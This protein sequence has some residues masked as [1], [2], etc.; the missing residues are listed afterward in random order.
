MRRFRWSDL[1]LAP[2][3]RRAYVKGASAALVL[4]TLTGCG[5]TP[6]AAP[7][8]PPGL[9]SLTIS[10]ATLSASAIDDTLPFTATVRD[11]AGSTRSDV[12]VTWSSSAP[13]IARSLGGGRFLAAGEG[14]AVI[15]AGTGRLLDSATVTVQQAATVVTIS[16]PDTNLQLGGTLQLA[17]SA[18]DARGH[19]MAPTFSWAV[20]DPTV[21]GID[22]IGLLT[23]RALGAFVARASVGSRSASLQLRTVTRYVQVEA[24]YYEW[25]AC[26]LDEAGRV[27]CWGW[28]IPPYWGTYHYVPTVVQPGPF[29]TM[30]PGQSFGCGVDAAGAVFCWGANDYS[31]LGSTSAGDGSREPVAVDGGH[32]FTT[33]S[34]GP[35]KTCGV[36][37]DG[38]GI[39]W[40]RNM[41]GELG[42]ET[43]DSSGLPDAISGGRA[44]RS[45]SARTLYGGC[46]V[47][48]TDS[49]FCWGDNVW[50]LLGDSTLTQS[51]V[52]IPVRPDL[53]F[54]DVDAA[55]PACAMTSD[56]LVYCWGTY[57]G[58]VPVEVLLPG[59]AARITAGGGH[60]CAILTD[61]RAY[62]WGNNANGT[63]GD[64]S[65][66]FSGEP[67]AVLGGHTFA[68]ISASMYRTCGVTTDH[69]LY[70]WGQWTGDGTATSR[71]VPVLVS[72]Q[73]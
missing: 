15:T 23:G 62:C 54:R 14:S 31:V 39:C 16:A 17:A 2:T 6:P 64:G 20:S 66:T 24:G 9:A 22:T 34:V 44:W 61:G 73:P 71:N 59:P 37:A 12:T 28:S 47:T 25:P 4:A 55:E 11:S 53:A 33:L 70:C 26:A 40:G 57:F 13:A 27:L 63:L 30:G 35:W 51:S 1:W 36:R 50:G 19:A 48:L 56:D 58:Q 68:S 60:A 7:P 21:A 42:R 3:A 41:A 8:E 52:P 67:R 46:G 18:F 38:V 10:P 65:F 45:V 49:L 43:S 5:S 69:R 29:T 72:F 32:V